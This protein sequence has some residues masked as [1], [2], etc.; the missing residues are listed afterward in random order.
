MCAGCQYE[1]DSHEDRRFH[2]QPNACSDCGPRL[3]AWPTDAD[4]VVPFVQAATALANG[5]IV[6]LKAV[7]GFQLM[8]DACNQ[9]AVQRLR[10]RKHRD[11]KPF[12][13]MMPSIEVVRRYC[14]VSALEAE[15]LLSPAAPI[16]LLEAADGYDLVTDIT[17][18]SPS[19]GVMLPSSPMHHLL[20]AQFPFPI[21]ATSGNLEG[22]PIAIDNE[23]ATTRLGEIAD[24]FLL[25]NRT[26]AHACDDSVARVLNGVQI[27]RR[28]RGYAPLPVLIPEP[29]RPAL[30]VGGHLKNSVAI[31]LGRQVFLSQHVGDL[32]SL[33]S[34]EAFE[35]TID[36]LCELYRFE[37]EA[38]VSDLHPDYAST[39]WAVDRARSLGIPLVQVQH[40]HSHIAACAAENGLLM[41]YL[42]VAWDGAG[43]GLDGTIWGGEFF[44]ARCDG[45]SRIAHL[46]Q[47]PL[48]GGEA[49]MRDCSRSAAGI[50]WETSGSGRNFE[51][52]QAIVCWQAES[53]DQP[54]QALEDSSMQ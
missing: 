8:V 19:V 50:L 32:D 41:D 9:A 33:E 25:H 23:D 16:V 22:E 2:A 11:E 6:A 10:R 7:G 45:F 26:I 24:L 43:L 51:I 38:I 13:I 36:D 52:E 31:S 12:A 17:H 27:L 53:E 54:H 30:A 28:A 40:H 48:P 21:V 47:F 1:Y 20:M 42:G 18:A 15:L 35:R 49:A 37:P 44:V 3:W 29:L 39:Q 46:R 14:H 4:V 5:R 34:R